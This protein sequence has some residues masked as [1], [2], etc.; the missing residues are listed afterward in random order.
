MYICL[1]MCTYI[2]IYLSYARIFLVFIA[3]ADFLI[4]CVPSPHPSH[5]PNEEYS[6]GRS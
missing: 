3:G 6:T 5:T 2:Y 1:C 4:A